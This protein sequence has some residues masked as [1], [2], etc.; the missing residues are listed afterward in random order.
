MGEFVNIF[1]SA[2]VAG[3]VCRVE[4]ACV[5]KALMSGKTLR[6][7]DSSYGEMARDVRQGDRYERLRSV[8]FHPR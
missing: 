7:G 4:T 8:R 1:L 3:L 2:L 6:E 5:Q